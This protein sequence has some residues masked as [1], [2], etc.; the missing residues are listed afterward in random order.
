MEDTTKTTTE[1]PV[2]RGFMRLP[3]IREFFGGIGVTTWYDWMRAGIAP[4]PVKIGRISIWPREEILAMG[5][6]KA[7]REAV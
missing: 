6:K 2:V 5:K 3:E 7:E 1:T 4:K